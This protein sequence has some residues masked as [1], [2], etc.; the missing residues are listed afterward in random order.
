MHVEMALTQTNLFKGRIHSITGSA[1]CRFPTV[2]LAMV[3][4]I[5]GMYQHPD[6]F[7][8]L[9]ALGFAPLAIIGTVGKDGDTITGR[10]ERH[11]SEVSITLYRE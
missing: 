8:E 1:R 7:L 6:I 11:E 10:V 3:G 2:H 5:E 4:T 9:K